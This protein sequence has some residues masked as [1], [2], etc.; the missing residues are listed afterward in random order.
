MLGILKMNK[1]GQRVDIGGLIKA[2]ILLILFG[3]I[4]SGTQN[5]QTFGNLFSDLGVFLLV[6]AIIVVFISLV[7]PNIGR[8]Y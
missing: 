7:F 2:V 3:A 5:Y 4:L 1:K 8:R 6:I